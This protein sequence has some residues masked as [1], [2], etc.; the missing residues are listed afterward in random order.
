[1][2]KTISKDTQEAQIK[3]RIMAFRA[4]TLIQPTQKFPEWFLC[5]FEMHSAQLSPNLWSVE[6]FLYP[7]RELKEGERWV[8]DNGFKHIRKTDP[9]TGEEL[10]TIIDDSNIDNYQVL[11]EVEVDTASGT[12][13]IRKQTDLSELNP[14]D[15][16]IRTLELPEEVRLQYESLLLP[17]E[18]A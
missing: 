8:I 16:D 3:A 2:R 13:Q 11:F 1:M 14:D 12:T 17:A 6:F 4:I 7:P 5:G 15:F 9:E 18:D 10:V